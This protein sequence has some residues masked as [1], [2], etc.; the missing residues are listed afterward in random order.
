MNFQSTLLNRSESLSNS[1]PL[2]NTK[3]DHVFVRRNLKFKPPF[4]LYYYRDFIWKV[5]YSNNLIV[6]VVEEY[7]S[8]IKFFV[9]GGNN[10]NLIKGI[11]KRRPWFQLT[12]KQQDA[13]FIWTQIKI[14]SI[15][16]TQKKGEA[17]EKIS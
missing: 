2:S 8:K 17:V 5:A 7:D 6:S 14:A 9:G 13:Q 15:Y 3:P 12:D 1:K 11:M 16:S 4:E 10:S